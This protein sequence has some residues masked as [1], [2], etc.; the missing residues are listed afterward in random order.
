MYDF[1]LKWIALQVRI[2]ETLPLLPVYSNVY[3]D[4]FTRRLH[5]YSI[6][7]AVTWGEAIV[8]SYMSDI[9]VLEQKKFLTLKDILAEV[10]RE[11]HTK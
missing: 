5:D 6:T 3:F 7:D 10:D 11:L 2:S 9:E 4:F 1:M 8:K